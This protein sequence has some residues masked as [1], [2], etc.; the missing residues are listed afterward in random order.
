MLLPVS[1]AVGWVLGHLLDK[2]FGTGYLNIVGLLVGIV[3]GFVEFIR[4]AMQ[5]TQDNDGG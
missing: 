4:Q 5:D 3:G 1:A 2:A